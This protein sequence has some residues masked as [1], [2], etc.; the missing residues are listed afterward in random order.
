[1]KIKGFIRAAQIEGVQSTVEVVVR[2]TCKGR[3]GVVIAIFK[4]VPSSQQNIVE[5]K[6]FF[7]S[8][9]TFVL[10]YNDEEFC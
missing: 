2:F 5:A 3:H 1:M 6:S 7:P 4:K 9:I 8:S 10:F